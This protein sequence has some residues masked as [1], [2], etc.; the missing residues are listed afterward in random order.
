[1]K[2]ST[3]FSRNRS[4]NSFRNFSLLIALKVPLRISIAIPPKYFERLPLEIA[5]LKRSHLSGIL[6]TILPSLSLE[7]AFDESEIL[8]GIFYFKIY[9]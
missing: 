3:D 1:M 5:L 8:S 7:I 4:K 9:H 6:C 2:F